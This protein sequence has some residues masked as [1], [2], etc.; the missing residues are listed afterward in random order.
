MPHSTLPH[1]TQNIF[2]VLVYNYLSLT[3][4]LYKTA[5]GMKYSPD[6]RCPHIV[7]FALTASPQSPNLLPSLPSITALSCILL[8]YFAPIPTP[9]AWLYWCVEVLL[10]LDIVL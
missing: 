8:Q 5:S 7:L 2:Y 1:L 4:I 6:Q 9:F 3:C 10:C